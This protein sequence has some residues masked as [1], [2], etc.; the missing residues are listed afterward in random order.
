MADI[1][2]RISKKINRVGDK[3]FREPLDVEVE[4]YS[5][6]KFLASLLSSS[7]KPYIF[8][9]GANEHEAAQALTNE[10]LR[11]LREFKDGEARKSYCD[12]QLKNLAELSGL[13]K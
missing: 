7:G 8:A 5:D 4:V 3:T 13:V 12:S 10:I 1:V 11:Y 2:E 9:S 6:G